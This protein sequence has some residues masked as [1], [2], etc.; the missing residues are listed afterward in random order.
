MR[1]L[2]NLEKYKL[3]AINSE[4][5]VSIYI[6]NNEYQC[7]FFTSYSTEYKISFYENIQSTIPIQLPVISTCDLHT[8]CEPEYCDNFDLN[9]KYVFPLDKTLIVNVSGYYF[10][11]TIHSENDDVEIGEIWND[12]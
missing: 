7:K 5:F 3:V 11:M 8:K 12:T 6:E 1:F 9:C 4:Y 10:E 2:V